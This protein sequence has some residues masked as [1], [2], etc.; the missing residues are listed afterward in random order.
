[1]ARKLKQSTQVSILIGPLLDDTDFKTDETVAHDAAGIDV[2]LYKGISKSD[3]SLSDS[4]GDGYWAHVANGYHQLTLSTTHTN[5]VGP[6]RVTFV[7]TGV[8]P[9][10]EDFEVVPA[11][12]YDSLVAGTD[13]LVTDAEDSVWDAATADH[14]DAG[15][16]GEALD[17]AGSAGDPWNTALPGSYGAG[18]AGKIVGDNLNAT[19]SSRSA[20]DASTDEVDVG[21][22]KGVAVAGVADFKADVSGVATPGDAMT[23][24]DGAITA[25]KFGANAIA[26]AAVAADTLAAIADEVLEEAVGDHSSTADSLAEW[27]NA[28]ART[29]GWGKVVADSNTNTI[30]VYDADGVTVLLTMTRTEV[31]TETTWTPS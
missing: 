9:A 5:T 2:D 10:W 12:V 22:V 20:F 29:A 21:K 23:L 3:V 19:V 24:E 30:A 6:L 13:E 4:E 16:T 7:A 31:G 15:S 27:V 11:N 18:T 17:D 8:L 28:L 25:A 1:M 26:A 14:T